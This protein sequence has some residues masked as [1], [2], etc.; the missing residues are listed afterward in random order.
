[1]GY[2]FVNFT[3]AIATLRFYKSFHDQAW[4]EFNSRKICKV[5]YAR[6]Q[7]IL[8]CNKR[9]ASCMDFPCATLFTVTHRLMKEVSIPSMA[10]EYL[11]ILMHNGTRA[12][13]SMAKK[14]IWVD[15]DSIRRRLQVVDFDGR[16]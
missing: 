2:A 9:A 4:E 15:H 8:T 1:M 16:A 7:V 3:S 10:I 6:V 5:A 11:P 14:T 12:M 13:F